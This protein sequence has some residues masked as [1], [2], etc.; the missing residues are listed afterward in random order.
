M[1]REDVF[2]F[3]GAMSLSQ[4]ILKTGM[5]VVVM[6]LEGVCVFWEWDLPQQDRRVAS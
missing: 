3:Q 2:R 6:E 1:T 5:L 4:H